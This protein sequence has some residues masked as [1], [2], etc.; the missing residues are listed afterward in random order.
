MSGGKAT[1][2]FVGGGS[3][4]HIYPN[5]AVVERLVEMGVDVVPHFVVS[6]RAVDATVCAGLGVGYTAVPAAP[7]S[8]RPG[9]AFRFWKGWRGTA[10]VVGRL[11]AERDVRAVVAT[12]GF[13]S[14]AVVG[15]L[16]HRRRRHQ[17]GSGEGPAVAL[18]RLDAV[19]GRAN[20]WS[21]RKATH[22]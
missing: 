10:G 17:G 18:V 21:A 13:V 15:A 8:V 7:P 6:E 22:V 19:A 20:R 3:G 1:V 16:S 14:A 12:G 11:M 2:L 5:A 4:G 9:G